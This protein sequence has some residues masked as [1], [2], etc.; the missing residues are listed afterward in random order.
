MDLR[1]PVRDH[2]AEEQHAGEHE[3]DGRQVRADLPED[4]GQHQRDRQKACNRGQRSQKNQQHRNG[5]GH[6]DNQ[7]RAAGPISSRA[8]SDSF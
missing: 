8:R 3:Q 7:Q 4:G 1:Q 2:H 6:Q 5:R